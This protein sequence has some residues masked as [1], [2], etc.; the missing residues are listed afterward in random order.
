[1]S[2]ARVHLAKGAGGRTRCRYTARPTWRVRIVSEA[3][4]RKAS[5]PC[6]ECFKKLSRIDEGANP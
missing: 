5:N 1:M 3:E 4:F 6:S 2:D